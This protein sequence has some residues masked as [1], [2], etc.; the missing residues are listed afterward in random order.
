[1]ISE[2][3][4]S[5]SPSAGITI[6][7]GSNPYHDE[8]QG[9]ANESITVSA[10]LDR[11][12]D[13]AH[14]LEEICER[15]D[16]NAPR[17][18]IVGGSPDHPAHILDDGTA[19]KAAL[20]IW[21]HGGVPFYFGVPVMCDGTA[22]SAVGMS[23][24]L[25]S[26]NG[27]TAMVVNQMES[28]AYHGA[29][30][31]QGCDKTPTALVNALALLDVIRQR[32]DDAPVFATFAPAHVLH[33]GAIP[34]DL[35]AELEQ[36]AQ[37]AETC[38]HPEIAEDL[39]ETM[40]H[41]LQCSA[42]QA[43]QG[44]L[45]RAVQEGMLG[46]VRHKEIEI[47]LAAA[48]CD[49]AGGICAFNGTG[50]SSRHVVSAL[51]LV[52]PSL[53]FLTE[54]PT[55]EQVN[56]AVDALFGF[57]ND[58]AYG[59]SSMVK[60]NI[61]NAIRVHSAMGGSTNL[62][63]HLVSM[64]IHAGQPFDV[65]ELDRIRRTE[66]VPDLFDYSL[67]EGRNI[68]ALAKQVQSGKIR[69]METVIYELVRHGVSMNLDAPT[70]T[71][72]TWQQRL[73]DPKHLPASGVSDNPIILSEPRRPFSGVEVLGG[74]FFESAVVKISGMRTDQIQAFDGKVLFVLY[75]ENEED[76]VRGLL[77]VHLLDHLKACEGIG[78]EDLLAMVRHNGGGSGRM[79]DCGK[80]A[81]LDNMVREGLLKLAVVISGQGPEAYGM[82]EMFT[83]MHHINSNGML[84]KLAALVSDGRYSGVTYGAA[85]GHM[86]PEA[87]NRGGILYLRTGDVLQ[88]GLTERTMCLLDRKGFREGRAN[89]Y[90]GE[91]SEDRK[92]LGEERLKRIAQRARRIAPTNRMVAVTDA[93]HGVVPEM[94][95]NPW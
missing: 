45:A 17:I 70:V 76:A 79:D 34:D 32:R 54:P 8:V 13:D 94:V 57:C 30:V 26:R 60:E 22:Q 84:R 74:N 10:L 43:F 39:R 49:R 68:F 18:A 92:A 20:R 7:R 27:V 37:K 9:K 75:Y 73:S 95:S 19:R 80:A 2:P 15:L 6:E 31:L 67:T 62:V 51:G 91:L 72:T 64:M 86:T 38:G 66:R 53:E 29:F 88:L 55:P 89:P 46:P 14:S 71:G 56:P 21:T 4:A 93:A 52:H 44:V 42:N 33:G 77:D 11:A 69:G 50:N 24:S 78:H 1:M 90:A 47:R 23:Y 61:E 85:I 12:G 35:R 16:A 65:W 28:H 58:P 83:P 81:L 3:L 40:R 25:Q 87:K 63:M 36:I 48:T 82:P 41:I 59:V 5:R